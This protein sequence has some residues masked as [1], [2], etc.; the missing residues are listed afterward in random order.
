MLKVKEQQFREGSWHIDFKGFFKGKIYFTEIDTS[1]FMYEQG[2]TKSY[3]RKVSKNKT[4]TFKGYIFDVS[5]LV[6]Q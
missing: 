2:Y 6:K 5:E 3:S 1:K 4:I